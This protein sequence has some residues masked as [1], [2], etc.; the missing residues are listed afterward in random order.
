MT[1]K[2]YTYKSADSVHDIK[3]YACVPDGDIKAVLQI[4]HGVAEHFGR[5]S[6][7]CEYLTSRGILVCGNDH[8]GHGRSSAR[9]ERGFFAE[10]NGWD[11]VCADVV[12]F[13]EIIKKEHQRVKYIFMGHSMGSFIGRMLFMK[14]QLGADGYIFTATG[15]TGGFRIKSGRFIGKRE[16]KRLSDKYADSAKITKSAYGSYN[17]S[18]GKSRTEFDW[19]SSDEREVDAYIA[20]EC[21]GFPS[22]VSL[23]MDMLTG[24]DYIRRRKNYKSAPKNKPVLSISGKSD[25]VGNMGRGV[26]KVWKAM[27]KAGINAELALYE[28]RHELLREPVRD[29]VMA[30]IYEFIL[31]A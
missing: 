12:R 11:Y 10:K 7:L 15:H 30:Q 17:K 4:A 3:A 20:D 28:G 5:Y 31:K 9:E 27:R 26:T 16:L 21:C 1:I 23:F 22:S 18:Y 6:G 24:L 2:E 14:N 25:P 8:L 13:A 19:I 29:K